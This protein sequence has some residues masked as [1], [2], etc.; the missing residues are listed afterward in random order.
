V[1]YAM[2]R[3]SLLPKALGKVH[4]RHH[5]PYRAVI[6]QTIATLAIAVV[7]GLIWGPASGFLVLATTLTIGAIVV[8]ALGN[9]ALT[10]FYRREHRSEFN[11]VKHVVLPLAAV[12]LL[13]YVLYRTV[14]PVPK[15]PLNVPAYLSIVW[16]VLGFGFLLY[17][18]RRARGG[19]RDA[20]RLFGQASDGD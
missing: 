6:L 5:T 7:A 1:L 2:G 10:V 19:L 13:G 3:I 4:P 14:W 18:A 11:V 9:V 12:A 17:L 8:Y 20:G 15:Y 16:L